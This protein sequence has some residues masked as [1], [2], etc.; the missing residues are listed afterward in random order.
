MQGMTASHPLSRRSFLALA[1]AAAPFAAQGR[2]RV[3]IGLELYSVRNE[4]KQDLMG[5]VR[6]VAKMGYQG[7]EFFSPYYSWTTDYAREVRKLLDDLGM[8]CLSTH[9]GPV[10]FSPDGIDKAI[11]LNK[12]LGAKL[13]VMASAGKVPDLAGWE[14]VADTLNQAADKM[15]PAGLRAGFHNHQTE[16]RPIEGKRPM[17]VLAS[18]TVKSVVLQLDVGTCLEAGSDPVAWIESNPGRIVSMHLKDWSPD[19]DKRY[20]VLLGEGAAPWKKIFDAAEKTGG[21]E[22]YLIEQEGSAYPPLETVERC[23]AEFRKLHG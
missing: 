15:K 19:A 14:K 6:A 7:V 22:H 5:T 21:I 1:A 2:R 23:L 11:E 18:K 3:P 16:F 13:V 9:N 12:I 20:K 4:L 10:S 17:D 8:P